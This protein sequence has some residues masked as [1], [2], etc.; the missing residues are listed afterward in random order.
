MEILIFF[1]FL[2]FFHFWW[3][4][5]PFCR[6]LRQV[7]KFRK[8]CQNS[9]IHIFLKII[10]F[11]FFLCFLKPNQIPNQKSLIFLYFKFMQVR[12]DKINKMFF[13]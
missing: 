3:M 9:V 11:F 4:K 8:F 5:K 12:T 7:K 13:Y 6:V 1:S 10:V 2:L